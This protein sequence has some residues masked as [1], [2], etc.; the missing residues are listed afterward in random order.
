MRNRVKTQL[1]AGQ[2]RV[3]KIIDDGTDHSNEIAVLALN[4]GAKIVQKVMLTSHKY[5]QRRKALTEATHAIIDE[6]LGGSRVVPN[7]YVE[8]F[9]PY[10]AYHSIWGEVCK[11]PDR[12]RVCQV[13]HEYVEAVPGDEW[14][15]QMLRETGGLSQADERCRQVI[16]MHPD[17]ERIALLDFLTINQ[18]RSARNWL[19]NGGV[20]FY[21]IDNG[22][23]WFHE[24]PDND[25]WKIGCVIDDVLLQVEPWQF[26]SGVF[27]TSYAGQSVSRPLWWAMGNFDWKGFADKLNAAC[28]MLGLPALSDD[29][30]YSGL[31]NRFDWMFSW[32]QF[33]TADEYRAW[34][35]GSELMTPPEIVASGGKVVWTQIE[36]KP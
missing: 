31:K 25:G 1:E 24:Y 8:A 35:Q 12:T 30:R 2:F 11:E 26:I 19:T 28:E 18:D 29:W 22:M 4:D 34:H 33:P 5:H 32:K 10:P 16:E 14:R 6:L 21:A 15:G 9:T 7:T 27:T 20:R 13:V 36:D 17:A 23:A 3:L